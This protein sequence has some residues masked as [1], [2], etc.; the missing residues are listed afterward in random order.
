MSKKDFNDPVRHLEPDEISDNGAF[1]LAGAILSTAYCDYVDALTTLKELTAK[2]N[3]TLEEQKKYVDA[4][5]EKG[6]IEF[7][8]KSES[9]VSYT[10][11]KGL[12]GEEVIQR[13]KDKVGFVDSRDLNDD[14]IADPE[15]IEEKR[16][17]KKKK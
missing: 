17:R 14:L 13:I 7:F 4:Q 9:Y 10:L 8:Y 2:S 5:K 1:L 12:P 16:I 11:G 3:L 15:T 6:E